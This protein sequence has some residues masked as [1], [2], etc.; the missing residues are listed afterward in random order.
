[1]AKPSP[2]DLNY[3]HLGQATFSLDYSEWNFG[4]KPGQWNRFIQLDAWRRVLAPT[5]QFDPTG[6]LEAT[7]S[8]RNTQRSARALG[9]TAT[10]LFPSINF[11][12]EHAIASAA[13][14]SI[15]SAY[16]P[17]IGSLLS[18]GSFTFEGHYDHPRRVAA[19]PTGECGNILRLVPLIKERHGWTHDK[20]IWIEGPSIVDEDSGYWVEDLAPIQQVCWAQSDNRSTFLAVRLLNR[21]VL[22][23]P[24]YRAHRIAPKRSQYYDLPFSK[25]DPQPILAIPIEETGGVP[26]ADVTFN[27]DY[28]RQV[29]L[30]DQK[31]N[32]SVW[33]IE[34]G[35]REGKTY[36]V[37]CAAMGTIILQKPDEEDLEDKRPP[38]RDDGW[39]RILWIGD[40]N[41]IL[42]CNR[43]TI[44]VFDIRAKGFSSLKCEE[45]IYNHTSDW[46]LDI[47]RHPKN[48]RLFF[49]LTSSQLFLMAVTCVNDISERSGE[50]TGA[51]ILLAWTHFQGQDDLTLQLHVPTTSDEDSVLLMHSRLNP[52][53]MVFCYRDGDMDTSPPFSSSDPTILKLDKDVFTLTTDSRYITHLHIEQLEF[54]ERDHQ[55]PQVGPGR[56]YYDRNIHFYRLF[57]TLSDLSVHQTILYSHQPDPEDLAQAELIVDPLSWATIIHPRRTP[58]SKAIMETGDDN[59]LVPDGIEA[60]VMPK[61]SRTCR[62]LR[63]PKGQALA[64][65]KVV[66]GVSEL[67]AVDF[68]FLYDAVVC[69]GASSNMETGV[70]VSEDVSMITDK[71]NS[72]LIDDTNPEEVP[73]GTLLEFTES[74][75][76]FTTMD[77]D[78]FSSA[79]QLLL[80]AKGEDKVLELRRLASDEVLQ[81]SPGN[82]QESTLLGLYDMI[83]RHW[84]APLHKNIPPRIR[85]SKE[86]LA[87]LVAAEVALA[88]MRIRRPEPARPIEVPIDVGGPSQDSSVSLPILPSHSQRS[89]IDDIK[90]A[91]SQRSVPSLQPSYFSG[92]SSQPSIPLLTSSQSAL[93]TPE[94]MPTPITPKTFFT[95]MANPVT[96][97]SQHLSISNPAPTISQGVSEIIMHWQPGAD[98]RIYHWDTTT[99]ELDEYLHGD[100]E[101]DAAKREKLKRKAE[102]MAKRRK[103]EEDLSREK[104]ESQLQ[105]LRSSPG[106]MFGGSGLGMVASSQAG[107]QSQS[108]SLPFVVQS[109]IETGR[110]GGRPMVKK[111]KGKMRPHCVPLYFERFLTSSSP[112]IL[113]YSCTSTLLCKFILHFNMSG[114]P[115]LEPAFT[116][117]V[118]IDAPLAVGAQA[119][120]D[121]VIVPMVKG[122]VK[123]EPGFE[124]ALNAEL[125]GI[126]Y[127]YIH[128]DA[129]SA[130][131]RLDVR[132]QVKNDDGTIFAMYYKG[133]VALTAA[134]LG[135]APDAKT[136]EY[137]DS[138]VN[139]TFETGNTKYKELENGT[140]VAAGH[141][142]KTPGEAGLI[143]EYKVSKVVYKG[144]VSARQNSGRNLSPLVISG[145]RTANC[146]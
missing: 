62:T 107:T 74:K 133:T 3:G 46:I 128:N 111:K 118:N 137:G 103:R 64:P 89:E 139:F 54:G 39:A 83:M 10:D 25:I 60:T 109:Q 40:V 132:S 36:T 73:Q 120:R 91:S 114:F 55:L 108:Q 23:R 70:A 136:T 38:A 34:G 20:T 42:V 90:F 105:F 45:I 116:V 88:S 146:L 135:G 79:L 14:T 71:I 110:H 121:L 68:S 145:E 119:G 100:E 29:G 94:L 19:L 9:R 80:S 12:S 95:P 15:T 7:H 4:R 53:I 143:V 28:Q 51:C 8:I 141:F 76:N 140:Y 85:R 97:L 41:T 77:V 27:P 69:K 67:K 56:E 61:L 104:T 127:D 92:S 72:H 43:R 22:L 66:S 59:F 37:S 86:H 131:M 11:V 48:K 129:N 2:N 17:A 113:L 47:K 58:F 24:I 123:S 87:R 102:R 13:I 126:G 122:T 144:W 33:D 26:H 138:F 1:M 30:V 18:V 98:P 117:S 112:V 52:L 6:T 57:A 106:P 101:T 31:G 49:I 134:V 115:S 50:H 35:K 82:G 21:T 44:G 78:A 99:R 124:P 81:L 93:P 125:H 75:A 32:W 65:S 130:N 142:V 84:L 16:D 63:N 96:R 5:T